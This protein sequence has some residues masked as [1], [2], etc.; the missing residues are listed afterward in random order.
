MQT[1]YSIDQSAGKPGMIYDNS[2][3]DAISLKNPDAELKCGCV[4]TLGAA[5]DE[6][7]HPAAATDVTDEKKVRG[8]V[9]SHQAVESVEDGEEPG[10]STGKVV[11]VLRKGRIW[12]KT[13]DAITVGTSTVNARF[14]GTGQ[15]GALRGA[16][17][18]T[19]TAVLPKSK[20]VKGNS[21]AGELAVLEVDL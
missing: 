1:E 20:W 15:A 19:F 13:E 12:V 21:G 4:A 10:Y 8:V 3:K 14:M 9:I 11:P 17:D 2:L 5:E 7:K 18:S 6:A 16:S